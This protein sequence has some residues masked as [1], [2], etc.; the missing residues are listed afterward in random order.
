[1]TI[2]QAIPEGGYC[3]DCRIAFADERQADAHYAMTGH[4]IGW[5]MEQVDWPYATTGQVA[6]MPRPD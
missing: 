2:E 1:V 6:P 3:F 4:Q 5:P